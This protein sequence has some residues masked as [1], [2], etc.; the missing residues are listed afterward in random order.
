MFAQY[1]LWRGC[2]KWHAL[3]F[4]RQSSLLLPFSRLLK[5]PGLLWNTRK[6]QWEAELRFY[7]PPKSQY[8]EAHLCWSILPKEKTTSMCKVLSPSDDPRPALWSLPVVLVRRSTPGWNCLPGHRYWVQQPGLVWNTPL[9]GQ[10]PPHTA[11][12]ALWDTEEMGM[13]NASSDL[14][15]LHKGITNF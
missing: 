6:T 7:A 12:R 1:W 15:C 5:S 3:H 2:I 4:P 10:G 13:G 14:G 8:L 11:Q 9:P